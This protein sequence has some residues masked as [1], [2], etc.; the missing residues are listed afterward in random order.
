MHIPPEQY[1]K[2]LPRK[3]ISAGA[4]FFNENDEIL[5]VKPNYKEYW[6]IP[7]GIVEE[8]ES[9]QA[10]CIREVKEELGID[11][12][13]NKLLVVDYSGKNGFKGDSLQFVFLGGR[14]EPSLITLQG[15]EL[16]G[17]KFFPIDNLP[18]LNGK[19][20]KRLPEAFRAYKENRTIF[21]ENEANLL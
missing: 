14:I 16:T 11:F 10:A 13:P 20:R 21:Y 5:F 6:E 2:E 12:A 3:Y 19:M 9:P 8:N 17:Y 15:S 18:H 1:Y 7:G 4:L